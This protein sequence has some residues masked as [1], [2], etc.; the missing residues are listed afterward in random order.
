MG[1]SLETPYDQLFPGHVSVK[2][3][4][5]PAGGINTQSDL[6]DF[7]G[8]WGISNAVDVFVPNGKSFGFVRFLNQKDAYAGFVALRGLVLHGHVTAAEFATSKKP[9]VAGRAG[10]PAPAA[11]SGAAAS[12][13]A[14]DTHLDPTAPRGRA[15][16]LAIVEAFLHPPADDTRITSHARYEGDVWFAVK[17]N[18]IVCNPFIEFEVSPHRWR[19]CYFTVR[20]WWRPC[21]P[22][23]PGHTVGD[24]HTRLGDGELLGTSPELAAA[25]A[26]ATQAALRCILAADIDANGLFPLE[27]Y[28]APW[29]PAWRLE[30]TGGALSLCKL[31]TNAQGHFILRDQ[32]AVLFERGDHRVTWR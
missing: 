3:G 12:P 6:R 14:A 5:V 7:L 18:A 19:G 25:K 24:W 21:G 27:V 32:Q 9:S 30:V 1:S 10:P 23:I 13:D 8:S 31:L 29:T 16:F 2:L 20:I 11:S 22:R 17:G 15:K 4:S 28:L 26:T